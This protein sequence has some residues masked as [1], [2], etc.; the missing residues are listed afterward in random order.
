MESGNSQRGGATASYGR[1]RAG[2]AAPT[3]TTRCTT[4]ACGS[5]VHP[6][7]NRGLTLRSAGT[8]PRPF[9]PHISSKEATT[10]SSD[11]IGN[12]VPVRLATALGL[13]VSEILK[14]AEHSPRE[15]SV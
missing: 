7:E 8:F 2:E 9:P 5:F 14:R 13:A 1:V 3:M 11:R 6:T 10:R 4:P 12:A 15:V